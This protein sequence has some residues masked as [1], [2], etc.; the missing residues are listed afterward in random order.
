MAFSTLFGKAL[1]SMAVGLTV[2]ALKPRK[3]TK[4]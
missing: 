2:A 3:L 1:Y 4:G